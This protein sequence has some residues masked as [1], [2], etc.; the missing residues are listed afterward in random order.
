VLEGE[1][2]RW[3][4]V[5]PSSIA[6]RRVLQAARYTRVLDEVVAAS[7]LFAVAGIGLYMAVY[8]SGVV[9]FEALVWGVESMAFLGVALAVRV[10]AS[11]AAFY[12]ARYEVLRVEALV[13]VA[14]S[15]VGMV[16][17]LLVIAHTLTGGPAKP[18]PAPLAVYP[19]AGGVASY[20]L[21]RLV[22]ARLSQV[23][24]SLVSVEAIRSKLRYDVIFEAAGGLG[25]LAANALQSHWVEVAT[26]AVVGSYVFYGLASMA[27]E[28]SA[29]LV[30]PGPA[31]RRR[32]IRRAI[33]REAR[34]LDVHVARLRVEVYG[35]FAEAEVW[36][37]L[38]PDTTLREAYKASRL[39]AAR[40]VYRIPELLRVVVVPIPAYRPLGA[41]RRYRRPQSRLEAGDGEGAGDGEAGGAARA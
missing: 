19:L 1:P 34:R 14:L 28:H 11:R 21:E 27:A 29:Y 2:R 40:L 20:A 7:A 39:L 12:R 10:A 38:H 36:I 22:E 6:L 23:V 13:V 31:W 33:L 17:T 30:G 24:L 37:A 35:T 16:V 26:L 15:A 3:M 32:R 41:G 8:P 9:L 5:R 18:T 4:R 25:V